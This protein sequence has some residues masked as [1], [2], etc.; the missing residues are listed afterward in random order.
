M[1]DVRPRLRGEVAME[2]AERSHGQWF[3]IA[4]R[5]RHEKVVHQQL[6]Q[7]N[8]ESFLPTVARWSHWTDR[9]KE[10]EWPLFA[11]YCFARFVSDQTLA[12]LRCHGVVRIVSFAGQPAPIDDQEMT[13]LKV[14]VEQKLHGD[15]STL[16][17]EGTMVQV[18][19]GPL[20]GVVGRLIRINAS[21]ANLQLGVDLIGMGVRV[22]VATTDLVPLQ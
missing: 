21:R 5:S 2:V 17:P 9:R 16:I 20:R 7:K 6:V 3:A 1:G 18:V 4:T 19:A 22:D 8:I 15:I 12:V 13:N 10:I 14:F 11:G